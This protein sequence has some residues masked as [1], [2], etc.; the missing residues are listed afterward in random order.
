MLTENTAQP[1][2]SLG[3]FYLFSEDTSTRHLLSADRSQTRCPCS[4]G[5]RRHVA[6]TVCVLLAQAR[7]DYDP[8]QTEQSQHQGLK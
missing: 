3:H 4:S 1:S 7:T 8:H 5:V 6:A 2:P